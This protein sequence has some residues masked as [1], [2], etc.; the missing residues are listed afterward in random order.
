ME[1]ELWSVVYARVMR[2]G[3]Y[4]P[5]KTQFN[6]GQIAATFLWAVLHDRP[7]YW[8]CQRINWPLHL[9]SQS[10]PSAATLS[11]RLRTSTVESLLKKIEKMGQ[12]MVCPLSRWMDGKPLPI[13][14]NSQDAQAAYG[15][16]AGCMAK[17][18][19][20]HAVVDS[21]RGFLAWTVTAMSV[22]EKLAARE[23][24]EQLE[25]GGHLVADNGYDSNALYDLAG[26]RSI[27]LVV[28]RR[29]CAKGLGHHWQSPYRLEAHRLLDQEHGRRLMRER[30]GIERVFGQFTNVGFGLKPLPNWVRTLR[31]VR[32]WVQAKIIFYHSWRYFVDKNTA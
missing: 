5:A 16:A 11:R 19:K 17:G 23:L 27:Q 32:L 3:K 29:R 13:D 2:L 26:Q 4:R 6:D 15:R 1:G 25:P 18:Y 7:V 24:I 9:R 20:L 12:P 31:R 14:G 22:S 28:A 30:S 8:A 10:R 21:M